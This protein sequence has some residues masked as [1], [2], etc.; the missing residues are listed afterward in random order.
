MPSFYDLDA[1]SRIALT[2]EAI[3][4]KSTVMFRWENLYSDKAVGWERRAEIA[5]G[6]LADCPSVADM[7]CG[8]MTLERYL[9]PATRYLPVDVVRRDDRT[10]VVDFNRAPPPLLGAHAAACLGLL[11]YLHDP[12]GF[13]GRLHAGY[14]IL[15]L[16]Y[17]VLRDPTLRKQRREHAWVNDYTA[18]DMMALFAANGWEPADS[19][20]LGGQQMLWKLRRLSTKCSIEPE[21]R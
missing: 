9:A 17:N 11:E 4:S 6:M 12:E 19:V 8:R 14:Q 16:S 21:P 18:I 7:G 15:V 2:E 10:V 1:E 3:K 13:L 20:S 5:A